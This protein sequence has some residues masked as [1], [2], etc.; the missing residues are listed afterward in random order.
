MKEAKSF[1]L[2]AQPWQREPVV[3]FCVLSRVAQQRCCAQL[4]FISAIKRKTISDQVGKKRKDEVRCEA[5]R[6]RVTGEAEGG[7]EAVD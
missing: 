3:R 5:R 1:G 7:N 2:T 6:G 4:C